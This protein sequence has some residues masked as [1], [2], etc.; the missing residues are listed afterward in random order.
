MYMTLPGDWRNVCSVDVAGILVSSPVV[1][2]LILGL[3][4]ATTVVWQSIGDA[5]SVRLVAVNASRGLRCELDDLNKWE[6]VGTEK[7]KAKRRKYMV[8][9]RLRDQTCGGIGTLFFLL[10]RKNLNMEKALHFAALYRRSSFVFVRQ[11]LINTARLDNH[12][13]Q[14]SRHSS[15][16]PDNDHT[17]QPEHAEEN[18]ISCAETPDRRGPQI[19][20]DWEGSHKLNKETSIDDTIASLK[21]R[22][23]CSNRS[24]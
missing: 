17:R 14:M 13:P 3:W 23:M 19:L 11:I 2:S 12:I 8:C 18:S 7:R 24:K 15:R 16:H 9:G 20:G 6:K 10:Q 21:S 4:A 5:S 1:H 22:V